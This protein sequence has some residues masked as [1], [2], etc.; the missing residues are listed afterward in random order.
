MVNLLCTLLT[1]YTVVLFGR[2]ILSWFP[3]QRG[4]AL[5]TVHDVAVTLTE[6]VLGP[7][8]R[9]LPRAGMFDL[10]PLVV[11]LGIQVLRSLIGC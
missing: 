2:I 10:S 3:L 4:S 1:L 11:V 5:A 8:R 6:P 7:L 9:A